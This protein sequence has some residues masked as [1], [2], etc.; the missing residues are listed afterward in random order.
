MPTFDAEQ[1]QITAFVFDQTYLFK[2][3][4][5]KDDLFQQL[6]RYYNSDKYRFEVPEEKLSEVNQILHSFFY[7][8]K[9]VRVL[10]KGGI[11]SSKSRHVNEIQF[12][13]EVSQ[14]PTL[15]TYPHYK[16]L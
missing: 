16:N 15:I 2:Q 12:F 7:N 3:Y 4:F 1:E 10:E 11:L 13:A 9:V 6:E 8:L 14:P 5:D